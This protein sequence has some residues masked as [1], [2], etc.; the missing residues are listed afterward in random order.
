MLHIYNTQTIHRYTVSCCLEHVYGLYT[1]SQSLEIRAISRGDN[2]IYNNQP[3]R[4]GGKQQPHNILS[5]KVV[6]E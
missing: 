5:S 4:E 3:P 6:N 2:L 1:I